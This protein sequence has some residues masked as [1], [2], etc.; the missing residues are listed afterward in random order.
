GI[1]LSLE[2]RSHDQDRHADRPLV[3]WRFATFAF[4]DV[5]YWRRGRHR[6]DD[7][8]PPEMLG[9]GKAQIDVLLQLG[10]D[11]AQAG[12]LERAVTLLTEVIKR[13]PTNSV[14]YLNR[15]STQIRLGELGLAVEFSRRSGCRSDA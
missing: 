7:A 8:L 1:K 15:G 12:K 3:D 9:N 2:E 10:I 11:C 13:E 4:C 6:T 14:A 5:H